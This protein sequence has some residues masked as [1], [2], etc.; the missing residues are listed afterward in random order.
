MRDAIGF[1]GGI[2]PEDGDELVGE[3][4]YLIRGGVG[5]YG[6]VA[7]FEKFNG[8]SKRVLLTPYLIRD[9][10]N[11]WEKCGTGDSSE[12]P[13]RKVSWPV[14]SCDVLLPGTLDKIANNGRS[15]ICVP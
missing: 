5:S 3:E 4:V 8:G 7:G 13:V 6:N 1:H 15:K 11:Q 10:D 12:R 2:I 9:S 14:D